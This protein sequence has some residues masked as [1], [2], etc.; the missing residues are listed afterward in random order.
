MTQTSWHVWNF[1]LPFHHLDWIAQITSPP[2]GLAHPCPPPQKDR[3]SHFQPRLGVDPQHYAWDKWDLEMEEGASTTSASLKPLLS[4][5][6][7]AQ[8]VDSLC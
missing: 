5:Q 4:F 8:K 1:P 7:L 3:D 2:F 6:I